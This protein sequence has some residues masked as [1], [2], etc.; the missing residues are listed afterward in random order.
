MRGGVR[1]LGK[2]KRG[3]KESFSFLFSSEVDINRDAF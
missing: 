3:G 1:V 2:R